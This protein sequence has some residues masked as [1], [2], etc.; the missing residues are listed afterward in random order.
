MTAENN[1]GKWENIRELNINSDDYSCAHPCLYRD[2]LLFF[3]SDM[4]GGYGGKDIYRTVVDGDEC[5]E[6]QNLGGVINTEDDELFP[7]I[8]SDGCLFFASNGMSVWE[9]WIFSKAG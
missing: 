1:A 4:P 6:V 7:F 9:A 5:G 3:V 8:D 2:S